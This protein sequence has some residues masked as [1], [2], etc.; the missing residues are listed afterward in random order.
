M[1]GKQIKVFRIVNGYRRAALVNITETFKVIFLGTPTT[2]KYDINGKTYGYN[3]VVDLE[4]GEYTYKAYSPNTNYIDEVGSFVVSGGDTYLSVD[5]STQ[6]RPVKFIA[7]DESGNKL[8]DVEISVDS[9]AL[10]RTNGSGVL[11]TSL[12]TGQHTLAANK[13]LYLFVSQGFTIPEGHTEFTRVVIMSATA[14]LTKGYAFITSAP[15]GAIVKVNGVSRGITPL[16]LELSEGGYSVEL[17]K[18]GYGVYTSNFN[19]SRGKNTTVSAILQPN[20]TTGTVTFSSNISGVN[21]F[22]ENSY[23]GT[24]P[25]TA[26]RDAGVYS[27]RGEKSGYSASTGQVVFRAGENQP[28]Y[29]QMSELPPLPTYPAEG[30]VLETYCSGYDK[31]ERRAN[32]YGGSTSVLVEKNAKFCNAPQISQV[33]IATNQQANVAVTTLAGQSEGRTITTFNGEWITNPRTLNIGQTYNVTAD[34][35]PQIQG[36]ESFQSYS[37]TFTVPNQSEYVHRISLVRVPKYR[38]KINYHLE[39]TEW[40]YYYNGNTNGTGGVYLDPETG[41]IIGIARLAQDLTGPGDPLGNSKGIMWCEIIDTDSG[42]QVYRS[43][44]YN[45]DYYN[46]SVTD[47]Y[48]LPAGSTNITFQDGDVQKSWQRISGSVST[49]ATW[50]GAT[51]FS[52][53]AEAYQHLFSKESGTLKV[54]ISLPFSYTK[55]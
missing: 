55:A 41:T 33:R 16:N 52:W 8:S 2:I 34:F 19:V 21:V 39:F 35:V 4:T 43:I 48:R 28:V 42:A 26:T 10:G 3:E 44:N 36:G 1:A 53:R 22:L 20:A 54:D 23:V 51:S 37:G 32:G 45:L 27:Y 6:Q 30:T 25:T 17:T 15:Q 18:S 50:T 14:A 38:R 7:E 47:S 5:L 40:S 29:L 49:D 46:P 13:S 31:Y 12:S 11:S 9:K 24:T